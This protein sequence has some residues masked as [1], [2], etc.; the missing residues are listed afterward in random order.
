MT[1]ITNNQCIYCNQENSIIEEHHVPPKGLFPKPRPDNLIKVPACK[2][3]HEKTKLDDQYFDMIIKARRDVSEHPEIIKQKAKINRS[4]KR[5]RAWKF[6]TTVFKNMEPIDVYSKNGIFLGPGF[7]IE[8]DLE[9]IYNVIKRTIRG[10]YYKHQEGVILPL[11]YIVRCIMPGDNKLNE[12]DKTLVRYLKGLIKFLQ[13][14]ESYKQGNVFEYKYFI[15]PEDEFQ[16]IWL[17]KFYNSVIFFA[18]TSP[19]KG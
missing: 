14:E 13:M 9:R 15:T 10:L 4:Y 11:N 5:I 2:S 7:T 1:K 3:C 8:A 6:V 19:S 18:T 16:S 17:L 12:N